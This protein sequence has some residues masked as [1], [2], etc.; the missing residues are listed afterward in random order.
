MFDQLGTS[1]SGL[2]QALASDDASPR[3]TVS[4]PA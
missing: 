3:R 4:E 1:F 2:F